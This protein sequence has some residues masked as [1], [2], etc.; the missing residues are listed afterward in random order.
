MDFWHKPQKWIGVFLAILIILA[1]N[2][3]LLLQ[4]TGAVLPDFRDDTDWENE[5]PDTQQVPDT[6]PYLLPPDNVSSPSTD[7]DWPDDDFDEPDNNYYTTPSTNNEYPS[8]EP[9]VDDTPSYTSAPVQQYVPPTAAP[10][11]APVQETAPEVT[12]AAAIPSAIEK[13]AAA[14]EYLT[15]TQIDNQNLFS[16]EKD[17]NA[18]HIAGGNVIINDSTIT[19]KHDASTDGENST[20]YGVGATVLA[21]NGI[22]FISKSSLIS[23]ANAA[24][25]AFAYGSAK[26]YLSETSVSTALSNSHGLATA[27]TGKLY[28][29]NMEVNTQGDNSVP[30]YS[31]PGGGATVID[32]GS[33][34]SAGLQSPVIM[35]ASEVT[36]ANAECT[37][38]QSEAARVQGANTLTVYDTNLTGNQKINQDHSFQWTVLLYNPGTYNREDAT[39]FYM[40]NGTITSKNGGMFFST[41]TTSNIYL[42]N[43]TLKP[44]KNSEFLIRCTGNSDPEL[45]GAIGANGSVCNFTA[46]NQTLEGNVVWDAISELSLYVK[47]NSTLI[48]AFVKDSSDLRGSGFADLYIGPNCTW[49]VAGDSELSNLYNAGTIADTSGNPVTIKKTDGTVIAEGTSAY[50]IV[51]A[52]YSNNANLSGAKKAP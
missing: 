43:V 17:Q 15:D 18:V 2:A 42:E 52:S 5:Q 3:P 44:F 28:A 35:C 25:G 47:D 7:Y 22:G 33:Y 39:N 14:Q 29:W 38:E 32:G 11:A 27:E 45:W 50:T 31:G 19:R 12:T 36:L 41:N 24:T 1:T 46:V 21:T 8:E 16:T 6:D 26:M 4:K 34:A 23:E 13:Y 49:T 30:V 10:T 48:G 20:H 9:A 40:K 37:A 51:V